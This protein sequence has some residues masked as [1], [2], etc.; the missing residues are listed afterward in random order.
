MDHFSW[1]GFSEALLPPTIPDPGAAT[2][3]SGVASSQGRES[4][5]PM[6]SMIK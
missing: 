1:I 5:L 3:V 2:P 4:A 6:H